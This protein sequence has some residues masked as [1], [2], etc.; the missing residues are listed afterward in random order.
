VRSLERKM[1]KR[2]RTRE[3][4]D[5]GE[6]EGDSIPV[7]FQTGSKVGFHPMAAWLLAGLS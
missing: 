5:E 3:D 1:L 2:C 6:D 4:E 7:N